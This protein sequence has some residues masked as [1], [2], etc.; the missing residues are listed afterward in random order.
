MCMCISGALSFVDQGIAC[1]ICELEV[2]VV[3]CGSAGAI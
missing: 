1:D 2:L 3:R